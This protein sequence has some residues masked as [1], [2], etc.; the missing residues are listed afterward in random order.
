[1]SIVQTL[2]TTEMAGTIVVRNRIDGPGTEVVVTVPVD[3]GR[4]E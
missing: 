3:A 1:M 2:V 4:A